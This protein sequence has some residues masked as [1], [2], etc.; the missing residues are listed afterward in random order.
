MFLRRSI[1]TLAGVLAPLWVHGQSATPASAPVEAEAAALAAIVGPPP[2]VPPAV[3][4][5]DDAGRA[6][7]RA[8]RLTTPLRIDGRL[9]EE[10]YASTSAI[11]DFIQNDP[12]PGAPATEKTEMWVLFDRDNVYIVA[13]CWETEPDKLIANE[14]RR[15]SVNILQNDGFA[16]G[17]DTFYDRRNSVVFEV[18]AIGG[19]IDGQ[20][21]NER[22]MNI[23]WNPVWRLQVGR[24]EGGWTVEIAIPF[25]SL[26]YAPGRAQ[27]WGMNARRVNRWK[28]EVSYLT[29]MPAAMTL[30]GHFQ[31]SLMA[32]LVGLEAPPAARNIE[33]KPYA[34]SDLTTDRT[35]TPQVSNHFGRE[36]GVDARFGLSQSVSGDL[37]VNTDFA[38][39][40]ADEQQVN[41]T[42]FSLFFPEKREFFLEN[43]G[44]FG[45][46]GAAVNAG[47]T[48]SD[49]PILFYSRRIGLNAGRAVPIDVGGR[50]TGRFG[51]YTLGALNIQ[52]GDDE[53]TASPS[54]NF[55][56]ARLRR[57]IWRKSTLGIL[58]TGRSIAQDGRGRN[59]T[60]GLDGTFGFYDNL[61]INTYWAK[62]WTAG[63]T[64]HD[65]SYRAQ[66]D[67]NGDRYGAQAEH[68]VVG[69]DF[70]PEV[71]FV[72]RRNM[73][74]SFGHFRFSPRPRR[75][76][77]VRR[78]VSQGSFT[79]IE[80]GQGRLESR[81]T[82]AEAAIEYQ[83][84]DRPFVGY[85]DSYEF[86]PLPFLIATGVTL[87]SQGYSF[88]NGRLGYF[89]GQRRRLSGQF[90]FEHGSFY[91]GRKTSYSWTRG[92][93]FLTS[94]LS[95][96]PRVSV[97]RVTL[98]EGD[99]TNTLLGS[100]ATYTVTPLMFVSA[101]VQY[102]SAARAVSAN[103]R[104]R[105][106]YRPGSEF[107]VVWNEQ[108]DTLGDRFP[109]L[110]NRA[111]IV[112]LNTLFR[113]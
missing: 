88:G 23:D 76:R 49:T 7:L 9:D 5:R 72:R 40:E 50:V 22:N 71:G 21:T 48:T 34:V 24:F 12:Q 102:S 44:T 78:L 10:I 89:L 13:R 86:L 43:Q 41:L 68:L 60:L 36:V 1:V 63:R 51:R 25:K 80:N 55:T 46:G 106:E 84:G 65:H 57:D 112:K 92:R 79:Y 64:G 98:L 61:V 93:V 42:R 53:A 100:R 66:L 62:T 45:F 31:S 113:F 96:E 8:I 38:Q 32:T 6:T 47:A 81:N 69:N 103:V 30:R 111:L 15:D 35:A 70:N 58:F 73:E 83:N 37:T 20:V 4:S 87:P 95:V 101:L 19:R 109:T 54:T 67:Y 59:E 2:P 91:S 26:R 110:A 11:S 39:V 85:S 77:S 104:L 29:R 28:N 90:M 3:V 14:M 27:I 56:A 75:M 107:F 33:I 82:D 97:D 16:F 18:N 74:R 52:A 17:L 99:F 94:Q 105:W 108:R